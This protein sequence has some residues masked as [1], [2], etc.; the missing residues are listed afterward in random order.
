MTIFGGCRRQNRQLQ[1]QPPIPFGDDNNKAT[2]TVTADPYGMTNKK[3]TATAD[4]Y[5]MTD[6]KATT[7]A[8]I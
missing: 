1:R 8:N 7:T 6:K 4:P 5:G 3:A 2:A